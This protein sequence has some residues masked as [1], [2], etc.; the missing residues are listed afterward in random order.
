MTVLHKQKEYATCRCD[1][2]MGVSDLTGQVKEG[3]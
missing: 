3:A 1:K 2:E